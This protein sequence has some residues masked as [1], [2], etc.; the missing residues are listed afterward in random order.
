MD[1]GKMTEVTKRLLAKQ[2]KVTSEPENLFHMDGS[3]PGMSQDV[4]TEENLQKP[5]E[6]DSAELLRYHYKFGHVSFARL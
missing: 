1:L 3:E 6:N 2:D 5:T 4:V